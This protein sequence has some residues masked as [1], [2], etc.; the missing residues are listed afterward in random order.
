MKTYLQFSAKSLN[1]MKTESKRLY[2]K[3]VFSF[4]AV[5][6]KVRQ[7]FPRNSFNCNKQFMFYNRNVLKIMEKLN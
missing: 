5:F 2:T 3:R 7:K 6:P 1:E 4:F